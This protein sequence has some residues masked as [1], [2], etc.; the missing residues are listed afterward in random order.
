VTVA[1]PPARPRAAAGARPRRARPGGRRGG[2]A[3][4]SRSAQGSLRAR[5]SVA[6][7]DLPPAHRL[8]GAICGGRAPAGR[9][10]ASSSEAPA[11]RR[12]LP[13]TSSRR[14]A[15]RRA[16]VS[17]PRPGSAP[18]APAALAAEANWRRRAITSS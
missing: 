12:T 18:G 1:E 15:A 13:V 3:T 16:P 9:P 8:V 17:R 4:A 14:T 11:R 5:T 6:D 7:G 10:T 2:R